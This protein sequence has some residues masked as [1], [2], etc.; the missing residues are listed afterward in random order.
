M[1]S[2]REKKP[3]APWPRRARRLLAGSVVAFV[4][5]AGFA[6]CGSPVTRVAGGPR[7]TVTSSPK[8]TLR[9]L[10]LLAGTAWQ[11]VLGQVG[12]G[13][14]VSLKTALAAFALAFGPV[15][16]ARA[17][18]GARAL[19]LSGDVAL[20]WVLARWEQLAPTQ[21]EA[22]L[23]DLDAQAPPHDVAA[24]WPRG[25]Q[26]AGAANGGRTF[27]AGP[28]PS[29]P[30]ELCQTVSSPQVAALAGQ[31]PA[32][33]GRIDAHLGGTLHS[34]IGLHLVL[35]THNLGGNAGMYAA[36]C[37]GRQMAISGPVDNCTVHVNPVML[38]E[39]STVLHD[40]LIHELMHCAY[41][42]QLGAAAYDLPSWL[43]EGSSEWV[44]SVLG[45]PFE[46]VLYQ[47]WDRY[48]QA[49]AG[50]LFARTYSAVGF[51]AHEAEDQI[52]VWHLLMAMGAAFLRSGSNAAAWH[53]AEVTPR[54]IETWGSGYAEGRAP[55]AAWETSGPNLPE[56]R[57]P[58]KHATLADGGS[59][60][61]TSPPAAT[62]IKQVDI[63]AQV[64]LIAFSSGDGLVSLGGGAG[65]SAENIENPY[66]TIP[67]G[68][69]CPSGSPHAGVY[70][71]SM[72]GGTQYASVSD[73][74]QSGSLTLTGFSLE[75]YCDASQ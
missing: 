33:V 61:V 23:A 44:M 26:R 9:M 8:P 71:A 52:D 25:E 38:G 10:P 40:Y 4:L 63:A 53:A 50:S 48:L 66:C 28:A 72:D 70:F 57:F 29:N 68:C 5:A 15:P 12:P 58:L 17:P 62:N 27:L 21:R 16:G 60:A 30:N 32:V 49:P 41:F 24:V 36:G 69:R 7:I 54:F 59:V 14:H 46:N 35:N 18:H 31:I 65:S 19:I 13:G 73:G 22:V 47:S 11:A 3:A 1:P 39:G 67:S 2:V 37:V 6:S 75:A 43:N 51:F 42:R 45:T 55:G 74:L 20:D 56:D 34:A 64:V